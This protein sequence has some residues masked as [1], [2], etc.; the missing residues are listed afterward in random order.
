[1]SILFDDFLFNFQIGSAF[2]S[3][4]AKPTTGFGLGSTSTANTGFGGFASTG[5]N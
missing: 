2:G 5:K 3:F 4:G 1:M